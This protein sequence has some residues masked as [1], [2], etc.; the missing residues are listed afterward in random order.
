MAVKTDTQGN[1]EKHKKTDTVKDRKGKKG[2]KLNLLT[3]Q[4]T[5]YRSMRRPNFL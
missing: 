1:K 2:E 3:I 5:P 4:M